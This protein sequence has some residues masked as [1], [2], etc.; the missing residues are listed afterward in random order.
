MGQA[1]QGKR[2][3]VLRIAN[4]HVLER[5]ARFV[6]ELICQVDAAD[7][8][9]GRE[10]RRTLFEDALANCARGME[11]ASF[12]RFAHKSVHLAETLNAPVLG[13]PLYGKPP[14]DVGLRQIGIVLGHQALHARVL[15]FVHPTQNRPMRFEVEPPPDFLRALE[16]VR[17]IGA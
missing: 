12:E 1:E 16:G 11:V 2:L 4:H 15:G 6:P 9:P 7:E 8:V 17:G 3:D 5:R 13:D 14:R 10:I